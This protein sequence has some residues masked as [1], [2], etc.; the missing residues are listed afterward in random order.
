MIRKVTHKD[1]SQIREIYNYYILNS[2]VNFEE[3]PVS[4]DKMKEIIETIS[5]KFLWI[6]YEEDEKILG[7]AYASTWKARS[8]YLHTAET[9]VYLK[10]GEFKKGIGT[11]LYKELISQLKKLKFHVLIGGIAL[12]NNASIALH[13]KQGF[14]KVAHFKEV[15]FK[16]NQW[17]DVEYWELRLN[18][19]K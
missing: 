17:L 6:V 1:T 18:K 4:M 9:S 8:G 19:L 12:P 14:E 5:S 10:Q 15:G 7:Y 16:F 13:K 2:I 11:M 3:K